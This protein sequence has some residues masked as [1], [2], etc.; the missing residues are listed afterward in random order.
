MPDEIGGFQTSGQSWAERAD[1]GELSAVISPTGPER[2][3]QFVHSTQIVGAR[4]AAALA[5]RTGVVLDFGCGTGRFLR[6]FGAK[7]YRMVG[8]EIT[9]EMLRNARRF[10]VPS[11]SMLL[12]TDGISIP[13][14][15]RSIDLIWCCTVLRY[16]LL[17]ENPVYADIAREMYRV[18]K[19]GGQVVNLEM[20]VDNPPETFV[21]D[22]EATGFTTRFV[23]VTHRWSGRLESVLQFPWVPNSMLP[24]AGRLC[25]SLRLL[26]DNPHHDRPGLRDYMFVFAKPAS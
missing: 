17:V 13:A 2:S 5:P 22:F 12:R 14:Q 11:R 15:A 24:L 1:K 20:Y 26:A 23:R 7:G 25:A 16:S 9:L 21:R 19:P 6:Y 18:L 3:N 8:T 10:G 4:I